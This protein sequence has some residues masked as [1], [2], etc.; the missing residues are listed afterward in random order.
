M[1][2]LRTFA[3]ALLVATTTVALLAHDEKPQK[4]EMRMMQFDADRAVMIDEVGMVVTEKDGRLTVDFVAPKEQR[5]KA[6]AEVD[7]AAGDEVGMA[8]GKKVGSAKALRAAYDS[9]NVGGEFKLGLRRDGRAFIV[10]FNKMDP[11]EMPRKRMIIRSGDGDGGGKD[12]GVERDVLPALGVALEL[13]K[14]GVEITETFPNAPKE[15]SK[16]DIIVGLNGTAVKDLGAFSG[17]YDK[18]DEGGELKFEILRAG[19]THTVVTKRNKPQ[20]RVIV[21]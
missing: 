6:T 11:K 14:K 20:G 16:G 3:I 4:K 18:V 17:V 21:D 1:N 7:V 8:A 19:K 9:V 10:T 15:M 12:D 13:T 5:P 2:N